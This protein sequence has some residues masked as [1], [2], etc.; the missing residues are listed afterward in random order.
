MFWAIRV[1]CLSFASEVSANA[2]D[3]DLRRI[4]LP[5]PT[6]QISLLNA[7]CLLVL[8]TIVSR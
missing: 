4:A 3:S 5:G 6:I 7:I 1:L 8:K 2:R